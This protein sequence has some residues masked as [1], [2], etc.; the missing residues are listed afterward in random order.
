M[1]T[2]RPIGFTA[3]LSGPGTLMVET[4]QAVFTDTIETIGLSTTLLLETEVEIESTST[5]RKTSLSETTVNGGTSTVF[6]TKT[7]V[8]RHSR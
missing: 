3:T 4:L 2:T 8:H 5:A 1:T 6:I 7:V